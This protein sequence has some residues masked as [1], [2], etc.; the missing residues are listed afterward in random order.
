[1]DS[2]EAIVLPQITE[3]RIH[4]RFSVPAAVVNQHG[5]VSE[6]DEG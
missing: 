2:P 3:S 5:R 6:Q 4:R 1:V